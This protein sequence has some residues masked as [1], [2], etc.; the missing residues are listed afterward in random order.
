MPASRVR[1]G[2]PSPRGPLSMS[3][4][5]VCDTYF[6]SAS[7]STRRPIQGKRS[8]SDRWTLSLA[9][10]SRLCAAWSGVNAS[11]IGDGAR[12]CT[13]LG[14]RDDDA[15]RCVAIDNRA[16]AGRGSHGNQGAICR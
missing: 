6:A 1:V 15:L 10:C 7:L 9:I 14:P 12:F 11:L 2:N 4:E 16:Y 8:S 5:V 3:C 13:A